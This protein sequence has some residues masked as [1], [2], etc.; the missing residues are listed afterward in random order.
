MTTHKAYLIVIC[1][2]ETNAVLSAT[3]WSSPEWEQSRTLDE[4]TYVAYETKGAS[5]QEAHDRILSVIQDPSSRYH[6]LWKYTEGY[7]PPILFRPSDN[8]AFGLTE[9][10]QYKHVSSEGIQAYDL[11]F[12][13][14]MGFRPNSFSL[15]ELE[16][17]NSVRIDCFINN[18][19]SQ[20]RITQKELK[21]LF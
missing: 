7:K 15:E 13:V 16:R 1:N 8:A 19:P 14:E 5:Y 9:K 18:Q 12:L 2:S 3:I 11:E 20:I 10:G 17:R 4:R 6:W 21:K